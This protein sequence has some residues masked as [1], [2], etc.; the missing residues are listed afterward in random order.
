MYV[1]YREILG[2]GKLYFQT[3]DGDSPRWTTDKSQAFQF[4][5]KKAALQKSDKTGLYVLIVEKL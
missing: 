3:N 5:T 4:Q 1:V 2:G